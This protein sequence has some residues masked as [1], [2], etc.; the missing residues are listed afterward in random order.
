MLF[1]VGW[2]GMELNPYGLMEAYVS[3]EYIYAVQQP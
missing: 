1:Y 3:P 2:S